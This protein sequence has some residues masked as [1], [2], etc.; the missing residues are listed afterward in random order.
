M[1]DIIDTRVG[2]P[3]FDNSRRN[4][5]SEGLVNQIGSQQ[6]VSREIEGVEVNGIKVEARLI[7]PVS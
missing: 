3:S 4:N 5:R 2:Q 6:F 7:P 1:S